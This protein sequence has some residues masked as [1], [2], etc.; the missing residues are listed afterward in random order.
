VKVHVDLGAAF[1][2]STGNTK[3]RFGSDYARPHLVLNLEQTTGPGLTPKMRQPV[4]R[5][6]HGMEKMSQWIVSQAVYS[7]VQVAAVQRLEQGIWIA[8]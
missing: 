2:L 7:E 8:E 5:Q 4:K 6:K 3:E 1:V